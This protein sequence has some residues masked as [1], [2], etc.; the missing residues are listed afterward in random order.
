MKLVENLGVLFLGIWLITRSVFTLFPLEMP[1][2]E[3]YFGIVAVI[4]GLLMFF[5]LRDSK[6]LVSVATLLLCLFL[7][8]SGLETVAGI[9]V[10]AVD[11]ILP[12]LAA[13][14]GVLFLPSLSD[15][16]S[17]YSLGLFFLGLWLISL[18]VLP[19]FG[20]TLPAYAIGQSLAGILSSLLLLLGM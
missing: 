1:R 11:S 16:H 2:S 17:F 5:R 7:I 13:L 19:F 14:S 4:A 6:P 18:F 8:L 3:F 20:L 15:Y 12:V 10:P 9:Q